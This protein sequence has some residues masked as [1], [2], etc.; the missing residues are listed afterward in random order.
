MRQQWPIL[1]P[2]V[3][4]SLP[5]MPRKESSTQRFSP[6]WTGQ[7]KDV[8]L[9]LTGLYGPAKLWKRY[10]APGADFSKQNL[11][12]GWIL[13]RQVYGIMTCLQKGC[14]RMMERSTRCTLEMLAD[15]QDRC[16]CSSRHSHE[17]H[18]CQH[19]R[20]MQRSKLTNHKSS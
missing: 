4:R 12:C 17:S 7:S 14:I 5:A 1:L 19:Q 11:G 2:D 8:H 9:C 6:Q 16:Y 10:S 3:E 13:L 20:Y 18:T 15:H